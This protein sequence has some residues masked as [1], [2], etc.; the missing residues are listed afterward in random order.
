MI[1]T[2]STITAIR[3]YRAEHTTAMTACK[4][5]VSPWIVRAICKPKQQG[6]RITCNTR[7][8]LTTPALESGTI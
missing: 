5:G 3:R 4:F 8:L 1:F 2:H 6:R 7:K